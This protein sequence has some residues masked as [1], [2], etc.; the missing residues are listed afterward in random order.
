[1]LI[2]N[3]THHLGTYTCPQCAEPLGR[4]H[5]YHLT[6]PDQIISQLA[7]HPPAHLG[8]IEDDIENPE[9]KNEEPGTIT[10]LVTVKGTPTSPSARLVRLPDPKTG[11]PSP[12]LHLFTPDTI[13]FLHV[14]R[15][16]AI[17]CGH[18]TIT[19]P[20]EPQEIIDWITP[21]LAEAI[22]RATSGDEQRTILHQL[23]LIASKLPEREHAAFREFLRENITPKPTRPIVQ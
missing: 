10:C 14:S 22:G 16:T 4:Y 20:A 17:G 18:H 13:R 23:G 15:T 6:R 2:P 11:E 21:A 7:E 3:L 12:Y 1:M 8:C 9:T 5:A 19:R